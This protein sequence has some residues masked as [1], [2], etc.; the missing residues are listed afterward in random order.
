M[1]AGDE[2]A[3][4]TFHET[5]Y[6][7]LTRYLLVITSGDEDAAREALQG[8]FVRVVRHIKVFEEESHFWNWLTVLA[9]TAFADQKRKRRR[10]VAFLDRFTEHARTAATG[11]ENGEAE[12]Q[13]LE[14]LETGVRGLST[15]ERELVEQKYFAGESVRNLAESLGTSEKAVESR[16]GRVRRKL[17]QALLAALKHEQAD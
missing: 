4:R 7:R 5:Y 10:Y 17:K 13:L 16:L 11:M 9:R 3:Y 15:E 1:V 12:A 6:S 2:T 8:T 14:A